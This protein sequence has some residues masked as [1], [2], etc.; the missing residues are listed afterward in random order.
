MQ[1][2]YQILHFKIL[3]GNFSQ[4]MNNKSH[5]LQ[6]IFAIALYIRNLNKVAFN[7]LEGS[8]RCIG[9][10]WKAREHNRAVI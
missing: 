2:Y 5:V 1:A 7:T 9:T 4:Q 6:L 10:L 3:F 8:D